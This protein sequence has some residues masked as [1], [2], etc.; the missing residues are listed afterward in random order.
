MNWFAVLAHHAS[1][2]PDKPITVFE[3]DITTYGEMAERAVALAGG[4][5]ECGIGQRDVVALLSYNCPEFLE[6]IFAANYLGAVAMPINWRLAAPEVRYILDHSG[7]RALVCDDSLVELGGEATEGFESTLVR[8]YVPPEPLIGWTTL[9][10]LRAS[11]HRATRIPAEADDIH[12][13]MYTSGTTG[14]PKGVMITHANLTWKN[15]AHLIEFGFNGSDL[16]LACGPLYHVGALDLTT[17][18]LIAAGATI[19]IHRSFDASHVVDEIERSQVTT[20]WLAPA[21]VNAIMALPDIEQRDLS[22]VRVVINGGEKMPIPLIE[23]IQRVF[24]SAWFADAY[25]LTETVSGDTFLDRGSIVSKLGSVGRPCLYLELDIWDNDGR[26]VPAGEHGEIVMRGPKVFKGY[27]RDPDAT[28]AAF[29]GGWFHTGDIGVRDEDGYLFIVDRLK[30]MIVSGG[31]NIASSEVER[32]LYE[33]DSVIEAAVVGRPDD[34]WG[35]VPVAFVVVGDDTT[36]TP[37]LL[38]EHCRT[39]LARFKVPKEITLLDALPRN[40]SGKVLKREL[41]DGS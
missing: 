26:S 8:A 16:G 34:R 37:D 27:W 21:M 24:S 18:S 6:T 5:S 35:E 40:P 4:L 10:D 28:L 19:I 14:R 22:T 7:A 1:R 38:L 25:G 31:E 13:L 20:V 41:R 29:A 32:V 23:R 39:Q 9:A 36:V 12:R 17:T 30:D 2:T 15:L 11:P 33:H 3:G